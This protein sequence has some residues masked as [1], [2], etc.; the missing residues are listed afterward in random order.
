MLPTVEYIVVSLMVYIFFEYGSEGNIT[1]QAKYSSTKIDFKK[2]LAKVSSVFIFS[3]F[4]FNS[5]NTLYRHGG[6]NSGALR[7]N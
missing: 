2:N 1:I 6:P 3:F 7:I 5:T 4:F